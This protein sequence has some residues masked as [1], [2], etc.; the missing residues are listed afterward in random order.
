MRRFFSFCC[1]ASYKNTE[2]VVAK[3]TVF[4][5]DEGTVPE[6]IKTDAE[7]V[8]CGNAPVE[9]KQKDNVIY[10]TAPKAT[11]GPRAQKSPSVNI[12]NE[13]FEILK[14]VSL[15]DWKKQYSGV[16]PSLNAV[17]VD[18][19]DGDT[20]TIIC[21]LENV[22]PT[23]LFM[24]KVRLY[25]IDSPEKKPRT[26]HLTDPVQ[27]AN[28]QQEKAA[29]IRSQKALEEFIRGK[30]VRL[31]YAKTA[32][33]YGRLLADVYLLDNE[34]HVNKWMVDKGYARVY[35]GD[36]KDEWSFVGN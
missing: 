11:I 15:N 8:C 35:F 23:K 1:G 2:P 28:A 12:D 4:T 20:I 7:S 10:A 16:K 9:R 31:A 34:L 27:I 18:V 32:D 22:P 36:K 26:S 21:P 14:K 30:L 5:K 25:G 3:P 6:V 33:K 29:A 24:F 13:T 19:Y 17:V